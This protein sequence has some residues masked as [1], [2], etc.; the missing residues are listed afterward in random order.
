MIYPKAHVLLSG[1]K[2]SM[3]AAHVLQTEHMLAGVVVL[4][5]GIYAPEWREWILDTCKDFG[6]RIEIFKTKIL[7]DNLVKKFGFPGPALHP[8][9]M[10]F[11]KGRGI[12]QFSRKYPGQLLAS[13]VRKQE[14]ARR[15]RNVKEWSYIEG[16]VIWAPIYKMSD[17]EVWDYVKEHNLPKS[18]V[19]STLGISGDCLCGAFARDTERLAIEE[20]YPSV[21]SRICSL[22]KECTDKPKGKTWGWC[23]GQTNKKNTINE[24]YICF[25]CGRE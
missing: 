13:G 21:F 9:F 6:W 18:P 14:S 16:S 5:T 1:G 23:N 19:Y 15:W 3:T 12:R 25:D 11:L 17:A 7:Y 2:D 10:N 4:D 24:Q 20:Y 8:M 22:E